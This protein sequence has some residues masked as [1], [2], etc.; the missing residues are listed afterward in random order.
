M[1]IG[2][3]IELLNAEIISGCDEIQREVTG[4]YAGDL[5]SRVMA[6]AGKGNLWITVHT[7][8]NIVAVAVLVDLSCIVIPEG[9]EVDLATAK[10]AREEGVVV[11]STQ[12][13]SYEICCR[14][15]DAFKACETGVGAE[16]TG[17]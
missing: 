7:N 3:L 2:N 4:V 11:L 8:L 14:V 9:I 1:R 15:Y 10:K 12:L 6:H 5:L 13:N 17:G 16:I